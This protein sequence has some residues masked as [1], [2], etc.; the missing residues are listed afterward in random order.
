MIVPNRQTRRAGVVPLAPAV[1]F[2][3]ISPWLPLGRLAILSTLEVVLLQ[4][5]LDIRTSLIVLAV[6]C[7]LAA[8]TDIS[9]GKRAQ[10]IARLATGI[11][12]A[13]SAAGTQSDGE[14]EALA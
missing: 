11:A 6:V 10:L 4:Y 9:S 3:P 5:G 8:I 2:A 1:P 7:L 13:T 14:K 12:A